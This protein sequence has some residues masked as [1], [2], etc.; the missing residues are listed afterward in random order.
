M[1]ILISTVRTHKHAISDK[2]SAIYKHLRT[3][4]HLIFIRNLCNL[5]DTLNTDIVPPPVSYD[6]E[7]LPNLSM[8][9]QQ[10]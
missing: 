7:Y 5:P 6:K 10:Y 4:D 9:I 2:E 1:K 3:C 8:I